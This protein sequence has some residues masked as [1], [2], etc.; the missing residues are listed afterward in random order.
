MSANKWMIFG[1]TGKCPHLLVKIRQRDKK[2]LVFD[3]DKVLG[4]MHMEIACYHAFNP[5]QKKNLKVKN[6][7][8]I[9]FLYVALTDQ[10]YEAM[11]RVGIKPESERFAFIVL[12]SI[13]KERFLAEMGLVECEDVLAF[14][15][16][17]AK[18]VFTK[19]ELD[20]TPESQWHLLVLE[21]MALLGME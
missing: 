10:I 18:N 12:G 19:E 17:K 3:A 15:A 7:E 4:R 6:V 11:E 20:A 16:E 8:N 2:I 5:N 13:D 21:R 9:I 14:T 1:A